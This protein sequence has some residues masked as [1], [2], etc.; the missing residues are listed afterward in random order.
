MHGPCSP[1][2]WEMP[3]QVFSLV[4]FSPLPT[5]CCSENGWG[6]PFCSGSWVRVKDVE[7]TESSFTLSVHSTGLTKQGGY[8]SI[9]VPGSPRWGTFVPATPASS[10]SPAS[11][12]PRE[13]EGARHQDALRA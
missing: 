10:G 1:K 8:V 7:A 6:P 11:S 13:E 9:L 4:A 3:K 2:G 5:T 12:E